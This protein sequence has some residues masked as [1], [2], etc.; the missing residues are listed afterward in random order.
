MG[1]CFQNG[2]SRPWT[3]RRE[4][5]PRRRQDV[6]DTKWEQ[7]GALAGVV[8]VVLVLLGA[9]IPGSPPAPDDSAREIHEFFVD[10][11]DGLKIA[12]T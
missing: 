8:F 4:S 5:A 7:Y 1:A 10:N 9:F 2:A 11:D 3:G 6:N 12:V